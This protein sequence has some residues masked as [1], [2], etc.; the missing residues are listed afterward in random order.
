MKR[1]TT[2]KKPRN[3]KATLEDPDNP[4]WSEEM[5]G[6]PVYRRGRGPQIAPTKVQTTIR[7]DADVVAYFR[8]M[9]PGYQTQINEA[10]RKVVTRALVGRGEKAIEDGRTMTHSEAEQ[11]LSRWL[12]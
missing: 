6:P 10:L 1:V 5:L 2:L 3:F 4:P 9:G 8:A 7:L 11:R 12:K